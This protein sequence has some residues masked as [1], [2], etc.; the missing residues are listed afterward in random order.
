MAIGSAAGFVPEVGFQT[1]DFLTTL[2]L[3]GSG[4]GIAAVP[5]SFRQLQLPNVVYRPFADVAEG[6]T[7]SLM[8][9]RSDRTP[10]LRELRRIAEAEFKKS[11]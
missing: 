6:S 3:V 10:A 11:E 9:R 8:F 1:R 7:L 2:A 5:G 4:L